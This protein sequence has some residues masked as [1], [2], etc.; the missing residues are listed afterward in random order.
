[1]NAVV[2]TH[3][4]TDHVGS[5]ERIR[6]EAGATMFVPEG[7]EHGVRGERVPLPAGLLTNL[8]RLRML[9]YLGHAGAMA[10]WR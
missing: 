5:A 3:Y 8:W 10:A 7:D 2:L 4:H 6:A 9:R 1:M